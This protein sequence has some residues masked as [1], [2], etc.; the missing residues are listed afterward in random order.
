MLHVLG[1]IFIGFF[2]GLIA[3]WIKPPKEKLGF[4][5]TSVVGISGSFLATY[6]GQI[7][8]WYQWGQPAGF[9]ASVLGAIIILSFAQWLK[10]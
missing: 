4:I 10:K 8:G 1:I 7:M 5:L 3:R 6:M 9:A 2:I